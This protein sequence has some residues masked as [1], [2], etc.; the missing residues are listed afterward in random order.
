MWKS[1]GKFGT[2]GSDIDAYDPSAPRADDGDD[3]TAYNLPEAAVRCANEWHKG[4]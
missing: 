2:N 4:K 1:P 3:A